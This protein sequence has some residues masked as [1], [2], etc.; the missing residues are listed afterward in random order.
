MEGS[1]D[2]KKLKEKSSHIKSIVRD[3]YEW[4]KEHPGE[5]LKDEGRAAILLAEILRF[6]EK[7]GLSPSE[8]NVYGFDVEML[9]QGILR[10]APLKHT[11]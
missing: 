11:Q 5:D 4:Q 6:Q 9:K 3:F 2:E 8:L 10:T 1:F 7:Q